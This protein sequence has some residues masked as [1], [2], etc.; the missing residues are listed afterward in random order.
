MFLNPNILILIHQIWDTSRNKLKKHYFTKNCS[1]LSLLEKKFLEISKCLQ[2][3]GKVSSSIIQVQKNS[4]VTVY[5]E[6]SRSKIPLF[7]T[8]SKSTNCLFNTK[9]PYKMG[10][11][12]RGFAY[13]YHYHIESLFPTKKKDMNGC[14]PV[15]P[16]GPAWRNS[17]KFGWDQESKISCPKTLICKLLTFIKKETKQ[18]MQDMMFFS[19]FFSKKVQFQNL[20]KLVGTN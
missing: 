12:C 16:G 4:S 6:N 10:V 18:N 14:Q 7:Q 2:I 13:F 17:F 9:Q 8:Y 20:Q 3:L 15:Q 11:N 5:C 19:K 1:D